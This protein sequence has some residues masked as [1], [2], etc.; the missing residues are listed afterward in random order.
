[1][2]LVPQRDA[3]TLQPIIQRTIAPGT[4]IWSDQWAVYNGL[5]AY[6]GLNDY[7]CV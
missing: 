7:Y 2:E 1:M 5:N 6:Y 3:A 4:R